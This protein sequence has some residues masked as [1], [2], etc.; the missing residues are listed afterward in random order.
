MALDEEESIAKAKVTI[1]AQVYTGAA[2][3]PAVKVKLGSKTLVRG[4]DFRISSY[5]NNTKVGLATV[6]VKGIGDYTGTAKGTFKINPKKVSG[7]K[8]TAGTKRIL[9]QWKKRSGVTGYQIQ[10]GRKKD[11][12]SSTKV[13]VKKAST[14]RKTL[15]NLKARKTYYV[16]IRAYQVVGKKIYYSGWSAAKKI[17]TK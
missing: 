4:T 15:K 12:S 11:F 9:V 14:V 17:K 3:K 8:L 13:K 16:R 2:L 7:L 5:K 10:Y 6:T 1:G